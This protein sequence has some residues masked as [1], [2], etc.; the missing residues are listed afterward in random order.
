VLA[1]AFLWF[2]GFGL[3]VQA[4]EPMLLPIDA[5]PL[6]IAVHSGTKI[7]ELSFSVEIA[8]TAEER[9]QGL[10]HRTDFP[11]DRAMLFDFGEVRP[12]AMWMKNTPTALDMLF[13]AE[14]GRIVSLA[15]DTEPF[16]EAVLASGK[17]VRFVVELVAGTVAAAMIDVGDKVLHPVIEATR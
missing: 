7:T 1:A 12:V 14:D 3:T 16:S 9:A 13:V 17:P 8:D 6:I 11:A 10:M 15:E 5:D 4:Q 2:F